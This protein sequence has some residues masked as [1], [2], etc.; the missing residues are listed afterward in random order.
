MDCRI[1]PFSAFGITLGDAHIIRNAGGSARD[2]LRSLILSEQL[3]GTTEIFIIKHTHC[4]MMGITNEAI[5]QTIL[6]NLGE[7]ALEELGGVDWLPF[8]DLE[9][10]VRED[11]GFL[12]GS[13]GIPESV[14]VSGWVYDVE[15]G[16]VRAVRR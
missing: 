12:R 9:E 15:T 13:K 7:A 2:A 1:D 5:N 11:V 8:K 10:G 3:L 14:G 16:R 4:G 6:K